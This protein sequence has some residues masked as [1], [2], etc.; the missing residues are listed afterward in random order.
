MDSKDSKPVK[1]SVH[2]TTTTVLLPPLPGKKACR[3]SFSSNT[4]RLVTISVTD[5]DATDSSGDECE[6]ES[7][8]RVRKHVSEVRMETRSRFSKRTTEEKSLADAKKKKRPAAEQRVVG[9][10]GKK[11]RGVRQRPWGKWAA[12]IRDPTRRTR[13]WLGTYDTAEEAALV[14]DRA[15]IQIRG[16]DAQTN[17]IKPPVRVSPSTS[18]AAEAVLTSVSG[19]DSGKEES[20]ENLC[21]PTS[22]LRYSKNNKTPVRSNTSV[23]RSE[24]IKIGTTLFEPVLLDNKDFLVD[25]CLPLDQC[26]LKDY[27]D[28]RSPPPLIYD[29]ITPPDQNIDMA[30]I[31]DMRCDFESL[32]WDVNEFFEDQILAT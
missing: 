31:D 13:V 3:R 24:F 12:E 5:C 1:F 22:V 4:P 27:F 10:P 30:A 2:K 25:E 8:R 6:M 19:Y 21:S 7:F 23:V 17:F 26:F 20:C 18:P 29:E 15:A 16:P 11:F 9:A 28:F 32:T 14:Y